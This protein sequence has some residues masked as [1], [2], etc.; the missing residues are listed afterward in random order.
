MRTALAL[1]FAVAVVATPSG[2]QGGGARI[3]AFEQ[4]IWINLHHF[5]YVL[6]RAENRTPDRMR[7]AVVEAP[8]DQDA[9]LATLTPAEQDIWRTA[10]TDYA[11][12]WSKKDAIFDEDL[13]A[14]TQSLAGATQPPNDTLR[15]AAPIYVKAWW[16]AHTRANTT[17]IAEMQQLVDTHGAAILDYI[18][19]RYQQ[20][21]PASGYPVNVSGYTNWAG[22]YS[23]GNRLLVVSSLDKEQ[24]GLSGL[25]ILFHESMHQW[26]EA[27]DARIKAAAGRAHKPAPDN[28]SHALIF[29]TAGQAVRSIAR[30]YTPYADAQ[31]VWGRGMSAIKPVLDAAWK[32][33]LDGKGTFDEALDAIL[34]QLQ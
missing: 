13:V 23:T 33:Y 22:A 10:V 32:P 9:G 12:T 21:W 15:R 6:G 27:I 16:P 11:N 7:R 26:D 17:R 25:E 19:S 24:S 8:K 4:S 18:T 2:R 28:L 20:K 14:L 29:Y 31:G 34:R 3:F 5:L 30:D 1:L